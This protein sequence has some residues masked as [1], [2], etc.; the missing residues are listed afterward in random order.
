MHLQWYNHPQGVAFCSLLFAN[1]RNSDPTGMFQTQSANI[2]RQWRNC[3]NFTAEFPLILPNLF[4]GL[5]G[6]GSHVLT[7]MYNISLALRVAMHCWWL[8]YFASFIGQTWHKFPHLEVCKITKSMLKQHATASQR[9]CFP[10]LTAQKI[11]TT[12][13]CPPLC[14]FLMCFPRIFRALL[15]TTSGQVKEAFHR[16]HKIS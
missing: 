12:C 5:P 4:S 10:Y 8:H 6:E 9:I 15:Q 14:H 1:I 13:T 7:V 16:N 2:Q 11:N 3:K